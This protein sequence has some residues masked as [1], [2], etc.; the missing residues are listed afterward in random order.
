MTSIN[1]RK[2]LELTILLEPSCRR[3]WPAC[4]TAMVW[5]TLINA[6]HNLSTGRGKS[7]IGRKKEKRKMSLITVN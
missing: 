2:I 7:D 1:N 4:M 6:E 5:S 3:P